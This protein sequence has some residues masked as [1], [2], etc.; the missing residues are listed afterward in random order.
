MGKLIPDLNLSIPEITKETSCY[1]VSMDLNGTYEIQ[2]AKCEIIDR[3]AT[4]I[5]RP[6]IV[7][8][9]GKRGFLKDSSLYDD[10][11]DLEFLI[12]AIGR[13]LEIPMAEEYRV[14]N[15]NLEKD[16]FLSMDVTAGAGETFYDM[17]I[18]RQMTADRVLNNNELFQQWMIDWGEIIQHPA[19]PDVEDAFEYLCE[20]ESAYDMAINFP[21]YLLEYCFSKNK[22]ALELFRKRYFEMLM[23]DIFVGQVD[24]TTE[25]YGILIDQT[26]KEYSMAPLFD[27]AT[28]VKP[29]L[30]DNIYVINELAADRETLFRI[31][32]TR[33]H[34]Y[35]IP[36]VEK[37]NQRIPMVFPKIME[38]AED[39]IE[40]ENSDRLIAN[41]RHYF[42]MVKKYLGEEY[43]KTM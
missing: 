9:N 8:V 43:D 5:T 10:G 23:F 16:S 4:G 31:L 42:E 14:L 25:N 24:R 6:L 20:S 7:T 40:N 18:I 1:L 27:C 33:Y 26:W 15:R 17:S 3:S 11:D 32:V 2:A 36:T 19:F 22:K 12:N 41:I 13:Y 38:L 28:M 34:Q 30:P 21:I 37:I 39:W 35:I 29:Y